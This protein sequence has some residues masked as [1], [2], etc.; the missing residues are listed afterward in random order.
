MLHLFS[1]LD[2]LFICVM[3]FLSLVNIFIALILY[4]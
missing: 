2:L 4:H 3:C 1:I